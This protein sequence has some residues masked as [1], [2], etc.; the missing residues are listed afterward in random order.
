MNLTAMQN[1]CAP[2]AIRYC[3]WTWKREAHESE[4]NLILDGSSVKYSQIGSPGD[5]AWEET[6]VSIVI[7]C[8]GAFR[9]VEALSNY[10]NRGIKKLL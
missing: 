3:P 2:H 5:V 8:T 10:F 6:D 7:E 4:G 1:C 9:T